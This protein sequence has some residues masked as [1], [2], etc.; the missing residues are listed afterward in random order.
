[1]ATPRNEFV[2]GPSPVGLLVSWALGP[3]D[4]VNEKLNR[5]EG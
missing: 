1:M 5:S 4:I 3:E 2:G